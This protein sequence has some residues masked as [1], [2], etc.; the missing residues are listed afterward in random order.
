MQIC[1][2][3]VAHSQSNGQAER[4]NAKVPRGLKTRTSKKKL[5]ACGRGWHDDLQSVLW[6]IRTTATKR[7]GKTPFFLVYR[8]E[9]VLPH[10]V[11]RRSAWVLTFDEAQQDAMRGMDLVL[12]EE[13]RRQ[14]SL[15][16]ARY[17]QALRGYHCRNILPRTLEVGDLVL[18]RV[19]SRE[20]LHK[21]SPMWE[22]PFKVVHVLGLAPH[23]WRPRR[24]CPSRTRG[25]SNTSEDFTPEKGPVPVKKANACEAG[26]FW[27][28]A[29]C[30]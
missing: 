5:E 17:Q 21:L 22:G 19:L 2:T 11:R 8:A 24:G 28:K 12:G 26:A 9:A 20:G 3:S 16:A 4:T 30:L 6:S 25:T 10:E 1:Y 27:K 15:R 14:A 18:R 13:R 29:Q 23:A 7:T